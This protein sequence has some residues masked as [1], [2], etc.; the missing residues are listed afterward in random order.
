MLFNLT[1]LSNSYVALTVQLLDNRRRCED[2]CLK[3]TVSWNARQSWVSGNVKIT[4]TLAR[5]HDKVS[6]WMS[7][8][9]SQVSERY[10]VSVREPRIH[11][12]MA[13]TVRRKFHLR[14]GQEGPEGEYRFSSTFSLTS[15]LDR[16]GR[17]TPRPGR[18]T[19]GRQTRYPFYR[20]M[21][22]HQGR[23]GDVCKISRRSGFDP[24]TLHLVASRCTDWAIPAHE[25]SCRCNF[26]PQTSQN[27][28]ILGAPSIFVCVRE[29]V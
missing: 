6:V 9:V 3:L 23:S 24:R 14:T 25:G 15:P 2:M 26:L 11:A 4:L 13:V 27:P 17:S 5:V 8:V 10:K 12:W 7:S 28:N 1:P 16:G 22:G 20:R 19:P 29:N 21:A 18:F